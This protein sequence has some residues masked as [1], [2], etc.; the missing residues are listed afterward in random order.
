MEGRK[1]LKRIGRAAVFHGDDL[2]TDSAEISRGPC[3]GA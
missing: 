2:V 3:N 1:T